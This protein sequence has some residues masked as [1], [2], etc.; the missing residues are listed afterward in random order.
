MHSS[1]KTTFFYF[2]MANSLLFFDIFCR[3]ILDKPRKYSKDNI[4]SSSENVLKTYQF[5]TYSAIYELSQTMLHNTGN[6]HAIL[7][8][9]TLGIHCYMLAIQT[10]HTTTFPL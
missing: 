7:S 10:L 2:F 3:C 1:I 6:L 8:R 9:I 4:T 5:T